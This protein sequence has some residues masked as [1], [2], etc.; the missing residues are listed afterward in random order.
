MYSQRPQPTLNPAPIAPSTFRALLYP[1]DPLQ[2]P[3][4]LRRWVL[5]WSSAKL[6]RSTASHRA[7]ARRCREPEERPR[8]ARPGVLPRHAVA[9]RAWPSQAP[10]QHPWALGFAASR[11]VA[12]VI[13]VKLSSQ[14]SAPEGE[15]GMSACLCSTIQPTPAWDPGKLR[16]GSR[17]RALFLGLDIQLIGPG[18][19]KCQ[20]GEGSSAGRSHVLLIMLSPGLQKASVAPGCFN[21]RCNLT[22]ESGFRLLLFDCREQLK[23]EPVD[24]SESGRK[25]V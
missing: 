20:G 15:Q 11:L 22:T 4:Q 24:A 7:Q 2:Q 10:L 12:A 21:A 18:H 6:R 9:G 3:R 25:K 17:A 5:L 14:T 8:A 19:E 1:A 23:V 13:A 16:S